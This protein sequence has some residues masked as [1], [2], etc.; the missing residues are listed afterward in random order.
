MPTV[1]LAHLL[2]SM[3][4]AAMLAGQRVSITIISK[5]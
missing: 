2:Q 3:T 4:C 5:A 1:H